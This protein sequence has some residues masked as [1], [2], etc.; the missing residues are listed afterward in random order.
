[1]SGFSREIFY[2]HDPIRYRGDIHGKDSIH[3]SRYV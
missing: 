2:D 3:G 1:M